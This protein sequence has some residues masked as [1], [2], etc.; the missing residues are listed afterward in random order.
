M[1]ETHYSPRINE[2][3]RLAHKERAEVFAAILGALP[4][5]M[6]NL[7]FRAKTAAAGPKLYKLGQL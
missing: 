5:L 4:R 6:T 7:T 2:A 3:Q 1:F